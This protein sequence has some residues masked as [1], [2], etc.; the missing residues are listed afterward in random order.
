MSIK[1]GAFLK[2]SSLANVIIGNSVTSIGP[3]AFEDC[4]N[5][6]SVTFQGTIPS[7]RFDITAFYNLGDLRTKYLVGGKGTYTRAN[8]GFTWTKR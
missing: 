8:G 7:S 3:G 6:T 2:C 5:L 4:S 1:E